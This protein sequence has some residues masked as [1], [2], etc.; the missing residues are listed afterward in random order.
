MRF[1]ALLLLRRGVLAIATVLLSAG[2]MTAD[3][4]IAFASAVNKSEEL[5]ANKR[6]LSEVNAAISALK[7]NL[8]KLQTEKNS[9][10]R[11]LRDNELAIAKTAK[12]IQQLNQQIRSGEKQLTELRQQSEAK[13]N[14]LLTQ[15]AAIRELMISTYKSQ[16]QP[17]VKLWLNADDP[18]TLA[19]LLAYAN[20]LTN[21]QQAQAEGFIKN[22]HAL[23]EKTRQIASKTEQ[24]KQLKSEVKAQQASEQAAKV[25]RTQIL[26]SVNQELTSSDRRLARLNEDH[27]KLGVVIKEIEK[28]IAMVDHISAKEP[29]NSLQS[30]L[31]WPVQGKLRHAYRSRINNSSLR[32]DGVFI[33]T[34]ENEPVKAVQDGRV[35]FADW[36]RG[37]GLL[38]IVDHGNQYL[39][40]YGQNHSLLKETGNWVRKGDQLALTGASGGAEE[41]GL[42]FEVRHNGKPLDPAKWLSRNR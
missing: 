29:F 3:P 4:R 5:E 42:Y 15:K 36:L 16:R 8:K 33:A 22:L 25:K 13:K 2:L 20:Y 24:V 26:A 35:V 6:N 18:H 19:R 17:D 7:K 9:H 11:A 28:T 37:F 39:T 31:P 14:E 40:L 30:R 34:G 10:A 38:I 1:H 23:Q 12:S 27:A 32:R 41:S 21:A